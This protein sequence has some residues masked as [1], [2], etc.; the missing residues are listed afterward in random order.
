MVNLT[1]G[2]RIPVGIENATVIELS[3]LDGRAQRSH[4]INR[5]FGLSL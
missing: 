3:G 2:A 5:F 4:D 1:G